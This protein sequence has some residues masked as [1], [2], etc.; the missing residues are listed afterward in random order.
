M[1]APLTKGQRSDKSDILI[2]ST[3]APHMTLS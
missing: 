1:S 3:G 2:H